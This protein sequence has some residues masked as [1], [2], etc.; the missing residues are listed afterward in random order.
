MQIYTFS[1]EKPRKITLFLSF[2]RFIFTLFLLLPFSLVLDYKSRHKKNFLVKH[3]FKS[4]Q[5]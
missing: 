2:L 3:F 5:F 4:R 1:V